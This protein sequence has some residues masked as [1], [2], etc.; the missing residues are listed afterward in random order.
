[1]SPPGKELK[2][3]VG[4]EDLRI[5]KKTRGGVLLISSRKKQLVA[6]GDRNGALRT[7]KRHDSKRE[8]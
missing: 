3:K 5:A 1:V 2:R 4:L 8:G 7:A 6:Y